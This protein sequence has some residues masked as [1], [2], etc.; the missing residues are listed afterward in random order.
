MADIE[1]CARY[2]EA[3]R[4][5]QIWNCVDETGNFGSFR[6][7]TINDFMS[8]RDCLC[9]KTDTDDDLNFGQIQSK[10]LPANANKGAYANTANRGDLSSFTWYETPPQVPERG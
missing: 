3:L 9:A 8:Y 4:R 1:Q 2:Q 5:D 7:F 10:D 6:H